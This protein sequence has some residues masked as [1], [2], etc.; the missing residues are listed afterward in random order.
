MAGRGGAAAG[1]PALGREA[2]SALLIFLGRG[3]EDGDAFERMRQRLVRFFHWKGAAEVESLADQVLDRVARKLAGGVAIERDEPAAYVLGV[4]RLVYLEAV[5]RE[6]RQR[7]QLDR[8]AAAGAGA[9]AGAGAAQPGAPEPDDD[10]E[11]RLRALET[12]LGQMSD[13]QRTLVLEYHR[14]AG[15]A[16]IDRRQALAAERGIAVNAL[17]I[18]VHRLRQR[19]A[20]CVEARLDRP[21]K[22]DTN[23]RNESA[24]HATS[25]QETPS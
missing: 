21:P 3:R 9:G 2:L 7:R 22:S 14:E 5:K 8:A 4:A 16:G 20:G 18:R 23:R 25:G 17:R 12:C 10:G 15:Q 13:E 11:L 6:V 19:L 24:P 1:S